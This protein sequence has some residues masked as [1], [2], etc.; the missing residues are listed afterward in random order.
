MTK[1][2]WYAL[3]MEMYWSAIRAMG[4]GTLYGGC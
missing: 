1:Q 4:A 2:E 3:H